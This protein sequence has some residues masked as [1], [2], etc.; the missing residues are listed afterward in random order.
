MKEK[1][2]SNWGLKLLSLFLAFVL[3]LLV[4]GIGDPVDVKS[5][6]N[7][8]V[9][10][11][12]TEL[13]TD[14]NKVYQVE[15]ETD[16]IKS[17]V[18][19]APKSV[20]GQLSAGDIVAVAD[21]EKLTATDT[22]EIQLSVPQY[23]VTDIKVGNSSSETVRLDIE[24]KKNKNISLQVKTVGE[25]AEGYELDTA[26]ADQNRISISGPESAVEQVS[27]AAVTVEITDIRQDLATYET[28][29]LYDSE[30]NELNFSNVQKS[31]SSV[32]VVATVLPKKQVPLSYTVM[33]APAE[34]YR[35]TGAVVSVPETVTIVGTASLLGNITA[36]TVPEEQLNV[37]GQTEDLVSVFDIREY[38][39]E[40]VRLASGSFDGTVTATVTVEQEATI[41]FDVP[42]ENISVL[43]VPEGMSAQISDTDGV[44]QV[45]VNGLKAQ[46]SALQADQITGSVDVEAW[47]E[48]EGLSALHPGTYQ[49]PISFHIGE[50]M[51]ITQPVRARVVLAK[52][53]SDSNN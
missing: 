23:T 15:D 51:T 25:V 33:G 31:S 29:R 6:Y 2:L 8:P 48:E 18:V 13:L 9:T 28:I 50:D 35:V 43:H 1:L 27:Y 47:M 40:G 42:V 46:V 41:S 49:I 36:I 17:V 14:A 30:G 7:I 12:N 4:V 53:V 37:T 20:L 32:R 3:W 11:L 39:P 19:R 10:L 21:L 44:Y 45:T 24:D 16:V 22:V 38:L 52:T 34:G 5:F 26:K